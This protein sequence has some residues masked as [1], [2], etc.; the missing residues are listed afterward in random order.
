MSEQNKALVRRTFEQIW[1]HGNVGIIEERFAS[2]YAGHSSTEIRGREGGKEFV[3]AMREAFPDFC[4]TV[5]DEIAAGDRVVHRWTARG[6][7]EGEFQGL[8]PTGEHVTITGISIY[9]V[10]DSKLVEGWTNTDT[11]GL[12]QQLGA[13]PTA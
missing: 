12:L 5:E 6:T 11:L 10:A 13:V 7:H 8:S 1:N 4:Y 2:D 3:A 9:R